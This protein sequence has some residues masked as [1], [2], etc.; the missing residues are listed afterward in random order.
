MR[1]DH[2]INATSVPRDREKDQCECECECEYSV[3]NPTNNRHALVQKQNGD[4]TH[5]HQQ[6][7]NSTT[8]PS[9]FDLL[10]DVL[11]VREAESFGPSAVKHQRELINLWHV[12]ITN[13]SM[14]PEHDNGQQYM[15][16]TS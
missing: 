5:H 1:D 10:L 9:L 11:D 2:S 14:T 15:E 8:P 16:T 3:V 4:N 7:I 12:L 6:Y 13:N